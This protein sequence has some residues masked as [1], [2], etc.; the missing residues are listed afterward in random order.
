M[1][2]YWLPI[3]IPYNLKGTQKLD[4]YIKELLSNNKKLSILNQEKA[5]KGAQEK[6][7]PILGPLTRPWSTYHGS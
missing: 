1:K 4:K 7:V 5:L 3:P 2:K 6:V